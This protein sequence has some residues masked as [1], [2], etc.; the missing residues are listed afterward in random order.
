LI[1]RFTTRDVVSV[2]PPYRLDLT[3]NVLQRLAVNLVDVIHDGAYY[4]ALDL[5][6]ERTVIRVV[7]RDERSIVVESTADDAT[8]PLAAARRMLGVDARIDE[9][10]ARA[11][12]IDWLA[13]L[14]R[15]CRGVRPPRYPSLWE[16]CAHAVIFQQI[17]IHAAGAIMRRIVEAYG[18]PVEIAGLRLHVFPSLQTFV[19]AKADDLRALGL[20]VNKSAHLRAIA[21][22]LLRGDLTADEIEALPT[23]QAAERLAT[24]RGIGPWSA[25]VILLRGFAR[26]DI[27][28]MRDSGVAASIKRVTGKPVDVDGVLEDLGPMRGM[29]Y[30]HLLLARNLRAGFV[31]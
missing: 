14:A 20:S 18:P 8:L 4:R 31:D 28:P 22:T 1:D 15:A 29:L 30:Y 17:S 26:L 27:F 11:A 13:P 7:Q 21:A 19:D 2:T 25:A 6:S 10:D 16:A 3:A 23:A 12:T 5:D 24:L 9:W